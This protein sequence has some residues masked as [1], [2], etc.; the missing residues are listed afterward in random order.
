MQENLIVFEAACLITKGP[1][2]EQ[3]DNQ[4]KAC[5]RTYEYINII[6]KVESGLSHTVT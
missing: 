3:Q 1:H 5:L 4:P 6:V 2:M